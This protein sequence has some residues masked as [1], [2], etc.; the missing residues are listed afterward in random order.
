MFGTMN[1]LT[2][3]LFV[4]GLLLLAVAALPYGIYLYN[5]H[6]GKKQ[7]VA[8]PLVNIPA[9]TIV[10]SALNEERVIKERMEN[11][12]NSTYPKDRYEIILVDDSSSDAT[13]RIAKETAERLGLTCTVLRNEERLGVARSY[14]RAFRHAQNPIIV[15]SDADVF[16][17]KDALER[18]IERLES[19]DTIAAVCGDLLPLDSSREE[20]I[21]EMEG[22]YRDYYGAMCEWDSALDSTFSFNGALIAFR[23]ECISSIEE[24]AGADD[25]NTAMQAIRNGYRA[26]YE[27]RAK[28]YEETPDLFRIQ[29]HQKVRRAAGLIVTTLHGRDL[30]RQNR[31]FSKTVYPL[32]IM[33]N[34]LSPTLT[35]IGGFFVFLALLMFQAGLVAA[36]TLL[37][38]GY[39]F[40]AG[41]ILSSF[42]L[43]QI[44][45]F[46]GLL[47][48]RK[49]MSLWE[50]TSRKKA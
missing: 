30:L 48:F 22:K 39:S 6:Y 4:C 27:I 50:S 3:F 5:I 11:I 47:R 35:L 49:D 26:V 40:Y 10:I 13:G 34:C 23:R 20:T 41:N 32:R 44:Y 29:F 12:A 16:F 25:A 45:L 42:L 8:P 18:I 36:A 2:F 28:V 38:L 43:N 21:G 17:E 9:I 19:D 24:E 31:P 14:N 37:V 46:L 1:I 33:I 7:E 15:T